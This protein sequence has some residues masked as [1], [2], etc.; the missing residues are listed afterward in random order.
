MNISEGERSPQNLC[1]QSTLP[2][3]AFFCVWS[4]FYYWAL[5]PSSSLPTELAIAHEQRHRVIG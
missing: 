4:D 1:A 3:R 5:L 2:R